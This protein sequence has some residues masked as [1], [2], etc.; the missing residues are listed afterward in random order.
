M[1]YMNLSPNDRAEVMA[2]LSRMPQILRDAFSAI[3][4]ETARTPG[5]NGLFSPVE[6]AWHLAD[7]EQEGF[8]LRIEKLRTEPAPYLPDFDGDAVAAQRNYR[9]LSLREALM[10]FESSRAANLNALREL[11]QE[12]WLRAG[13]QEGVGAVSLCDLPMMMM[14]HDQ[15]HLSEIEQWRLNESK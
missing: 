10:A 9:S 3:D 5:P 8:G 6:Q 4:P 12:E 1:Q 2:S 13:T 7:L 14:Q 15:A 11:S